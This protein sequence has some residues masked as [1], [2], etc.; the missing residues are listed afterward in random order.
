MVMAATIERALASADPPDAGVFQANLAAYTAKLRQLDQDIARRIDGLDNK[1]LVTD[2]DAFGYYVARYGL[3]FVG[4]IIPSFDTSAELSGKDVA[5]V[6]ARIRATG[7]K[8][9]FSESSLPPRTAETIAREAGV[10]VVEGEGALYGDTLG[11]A[12]S[13]GATYL[14]MEEHNTRT[15]V[16]ALGGV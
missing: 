10:K 12:G 1:R 2:H 16:A 15:I 8:A 5:D 11:P 3:Q 9:V 13:D 4:S 14:Q 6:V 7:V